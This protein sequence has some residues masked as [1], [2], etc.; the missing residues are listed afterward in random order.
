M[1]MVGYVN[2]L[3][4]EKSEGQGDGVVP[5]PTLIQAN[6]RRTGPVN[7]SV[8]RGCVNIKVPRRK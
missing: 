6:T 1:S 3:L 4:P 8:E 7:S 2:L 5:A